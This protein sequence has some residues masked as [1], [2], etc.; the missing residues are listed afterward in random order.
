MLN[1]SATIFFLTAGLIK[2]DKH[3]WVDI[4]QDLTM[5]EEK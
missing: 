3:K 5:L 1:G 2:K 4:F